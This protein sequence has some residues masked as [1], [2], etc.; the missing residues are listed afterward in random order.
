MVISAD[1]FVDINTNNTDCVK[2]AGY[3]TWR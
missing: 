3:N 2:A 1:E